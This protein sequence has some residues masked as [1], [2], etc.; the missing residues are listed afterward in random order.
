MNWRVTAGTFWLGQ[1]TSFV[2]LSSVDSTRWPCPASDPSCTIW[3]TRAG[4][5]GLVISPG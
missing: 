5:S 4:N 3:A 2:L 1:V